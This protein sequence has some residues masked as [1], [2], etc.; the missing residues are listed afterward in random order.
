MHIECSPYIWSPYII[1]AHQPAHRQR[2]PAAS[3]SPTASR[4]TSDL[5]CRPARHC[6]HT[7]LSARSAHS[8]A[9]RDPGDEQVARPLVLDARHG[10]VGGAQRLLRLV[11]RPPLAQAD[12]KGALVGR[13]GARRDAEAGVPAAV[14]A[15]AGVLEVQLHT[16]VR[17]GRVARDD[18]RP[19]GAAGGHARHVEALLPLLVDPLEREKVRHLVALLRVRGPLGHHD[20]AGA[21][22]GAGDAGDVVA[23]LPAVLDPLLGQEGDAEKVHLLRVA[24]ARV[25]DE[26]PQVLAARDARDVQAV[27]AAALHVLLDAGGGHV[28][29]VPLLHRLVRVVDRDPL[30]GRHA[31]ADLLRRAVHG[32]GQRL[33]VVLAVAAHVLQLR[34][35]RGK[36]GEHGPRQ[37]GGAAQRLKQPAVKRV[38]GLLVKLGV[39]DALGEELEGGRCGARERLGAAGH[40][41]L[42]HQVALVLRVVALPRQAPLEQEQQRVRQ[43]LQVVA[44]A[45]GA[46][47]VGV[48]ARVAHGA[49]EHVRAL[50]VLRV[51]AAHVVPPLAGQPQVHEVQALGARGVGR[52]QQKVLRLDVPVHKALGVQRLQDGQR[53]HRDAGHHLDGHLLPL[54]VPHVPQAG[55]QDVHDHHVKVPLPPLVVHLGHARH[56]V[57][58][59]V[60]GP[61]VRRPVLAP[62]A[63]AVL[64]LER[65]KL[66]PARV[67]AALAA[68]GR[69]GLAAHVHLAKAALP[70]LTL[71]RVLRRVGKLDLLRHRRGV[72]LVILAVQVAGRVPGADLVDVRHFDDE[73]VRGHVVLRGGSCWLGSTGV[74]VAPLVRRR[75]RFVQVG[76]NLLVYVDHSRLTHLRSGSGGPRPAASSRPPG[77]PSVPTSGRRCG[78][79]L[80][81]A[82]EVAAAAGASSAV[83][84]CCWGCCLSACPS[85]AQS[86]FRLESC[87]PGG[88]ISTLRLRPEGHSVGA[89]AQSSTGRFCRRKGFPTCFCNR[90]CWNVKS[91]AAEYA[92]CCWTWSWAFG[93][94]AIG[95]NHTT[96]DKL[97]GM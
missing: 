43:R 83:L 75:W 51:R 21:G 60:H 96:G 64:K 62:L 22:G 36:L 28:V 89:S 65:H 6:R 44:P 11:G 72:G 17:E 55:A 37:A 95:G 38:L 27:A 16:L 92:S 70:E 63:A 47:Q 85:A 35:A 24:G 78:V 73:L 58:A 18:H 84:T 88:S 15:L 50:V 41:L 82:A 5:A 52:P 33:D 8:P 29:V 26:R 14:D 86:R 7:R 80:A 34:Q 9:V 57:H 79:L 2:L 42:A 32:G 48:H 97:G 61:L 45:G 90:R 30:R 93:V 91:A 20:Q 49:A 94:R 69:V 40:L 54:V 19:A 10:K 12:H 81:L 53:L 67:V 59:V 23:L 3:L 13:G 76:G 46:A 77:S 74:L 4:G 87:L 39:D 31:Q 1:C 71:H 25:Q 56:R 66:R 68:R